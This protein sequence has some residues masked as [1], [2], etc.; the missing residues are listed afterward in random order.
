SKKVAATRII[1]VEIP[2]KNKKVNCEAKLANLAGAEI[3]VVDHHDYGPDWPRYHPLSS[4]E[5]VAALLGYQISLSQF[6][7]GLYDRGFLTAFAKIG[8]SKEELI[9]FVS[10]FAG[11]AFNLKA[12]KGKSDGHQLLDTV[13][14]KLYIKRDYINVIPLF[15]RALSLD[16]YPSYINI[17]SIGGPATIAFTGHPRLAQNIYDLLKT[18]VKNISVLY[19]GGAKDTTLYV[20]AKG[21]SSEVFPEISAQVLA[22]AHRCSD[23]MMPS[24][25]TN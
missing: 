9:Q 17:L 21:I 19:M 3:F 25:S 22:I 8:L 6:Y 11:P 4:L 10:H 23:L 1:L 15:I 24:E 20:V 14:G 5:Q 13:W 7:T 2:P 12:M 18:R 16:H